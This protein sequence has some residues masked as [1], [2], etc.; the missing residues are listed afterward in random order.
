MARKEHSKAIEFFDQAIG[1][2][3]DHPQARC[4]R[5][6]AHYHCGRYRQAFLDLQRAYKLD[7][8]IPNIRRLVQMAIRKLED[9]G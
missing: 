2:K 8:E 4:R 3:P 5:G 1:I 7:P 6:L 9:S